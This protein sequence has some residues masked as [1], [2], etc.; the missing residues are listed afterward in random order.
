MTERLLKADLHVHSWHSTVNGD[1]PF[2]KSR[3]CYSDPV[4]VYRTA[5]ARG[6]DIVTITDHD[7]IDGCLELLSRMPGLV[8]F[9]IGEEVSCRMPEGDIEVHLGVYG[10]TEALHRDLQ[11]LRR[12]VFEVIGR[13]REAQVF[14][15]LNHLLHFYRRQVPLDTYLRLVGEVP[16]LEVRNGTM[17]PAH[18]VLVE[19]LL[20]HLRHSSTGPGGQW[21]AVTAGSDA[22]TLRRVG[23]TWTEAPGRTAADFL[24]SLKKGL[25]QA[26]G[27]HGGTQAV[28]G[29]AYGVVS[30]YCGSLL[31][32]W[33]SNHTPLHRAGCIA[34]SVVSL[35]GQFL[36]WM[37]PAFGKRRERRIVAGVT[38]ELEPLLSGG[39]PFT[40]L[41]AS[42]EQA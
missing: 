38:A 14:F 5:K 4:D 28:A 27:A 34:F 23:R 36:P 25:G 40:R 9:I 11:P 2:L 31:G 19:R 41:A 29:D 13:L 33:P 17:V 32:L 12:S 10:M 30:R 20:A 1:L 21:P 18:N 26:C 6:M 24:D 39:T 8:D 15:S 37:I 16:A 3:D 35:P 42:E 22:H 7:S